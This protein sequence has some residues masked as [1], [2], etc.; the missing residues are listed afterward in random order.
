MLCHRRSGSDGRPGGEQVPERGAE[1]VRVRPLQRRV[2]QACQV[3]RQTSSLLEQCAL[4][5]TNAQTFV[6]EAQIF[7]PQISSKRSQSGI[8][9][10][11]LTTW[12]FFF[13]WVCCENSLDTCEKKLS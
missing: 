13:S 9:K 1:V 5:C 8:F 11:A 12:I 10:L 2:E 6:S 3:G 4:A 7:F